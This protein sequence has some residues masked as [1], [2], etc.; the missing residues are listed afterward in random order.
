[1]VINIQQSEHLSKKS[2][3]SISQDLLPL[4]STDLIS[5]LIVFIS[6]WD[7][8]WAYTLDWLATALTLTDDHIN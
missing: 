6:P 2:V 8:A 5:S 1:M 7:K 4:L 3:L